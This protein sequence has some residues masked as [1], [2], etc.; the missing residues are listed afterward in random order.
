[1]ESRGN[2]IQRAAAIRGVEIA[3]GG[4][5]LQRK[6]SDMKKEQKKKLEQPK[7]FTPGLSKS[8]VRQHAYELYRDKLGHDKLTLEDWIFAEKDLVNLMDQGEF[9]GR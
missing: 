4:L 5:T 7:P 9:R 2:K 3:G 8:A 1:L 6:E